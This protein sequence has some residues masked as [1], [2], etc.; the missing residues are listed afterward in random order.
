[1]HQNVNRGPS[2]RKYLLSTYNMPGIVQGVVRKEMD[3]YD[4]HVQLTVRGLS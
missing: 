3:P 2:L 1:M 4:A